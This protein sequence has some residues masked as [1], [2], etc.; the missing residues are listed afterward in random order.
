VSRLASA[1]ASARRHGAGATLVLL[2]LLAVAGCERRPD[3]AHPKR[4]DEGGLAFAYPGNWK[5]SAE[6]S[7]TG[8]A[9]IR[10]ITVES[11]GNGLVMIE[12]FRPAIPVEPKEFI[13]SLL[14]HMKQLASGKTRG[15][16]TIEG[17]ASRPV[18][19]QLLGEPRAGLR[20]TFRM[21][22]LGERVP[23]TVDGYSV[24]LPDRTL[25]FVVQ[26]PDEDRRLL[27][28][29]FARILDTVEVK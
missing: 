29:G 9:T 17:L 1:A 11:P 26:A 4:F 7:A 14:G 20:R 28:P 21:A 23:H 18:Q 15:L 5:V 8:A 24:A 3:L 27:E 2:A 19:R 12:E 10:S 22:A 25:V 16:V 13:D 6:T